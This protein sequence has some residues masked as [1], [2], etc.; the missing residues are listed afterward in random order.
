MMSSIDLPCCRRSQMYPPIEFK[1]SMAPRLT[2]RITAPSRLITERIDGEI[3]T[4]ASSK[5]RKVTTPESTEKKL[6]SESFYRHQKCFS[7]FA[8]CSRSTE[9]SNAARRDLE[10][11]L[12]LGCV[13]TSLT[14]HS[15]RPVGLKSL[16]T[17]V[18]NG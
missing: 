14:N 17:R 2:S 3:L 8:G 1:F 10:I 12:Y 6:F 16:S 4:I 11:R 15:G 5:R 7:R 9:S 18:Q 13:G